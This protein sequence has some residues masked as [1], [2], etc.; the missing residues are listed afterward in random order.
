[1]LLHAASA[2]N[3]ARLCW[4]GSLLIGCSEYA[5]G[6]SM[7]GAV[8]AILGRPPLKR[9]GNVRWFLHLCRTTP[10][11]GSVSPP[12]E[13][14]MEMM[15]EEVQLFALQP[16]NS[17][18]SSFLCDFLKHQ[19]AW[20]A[21]GNTDN[22]TYGAFIPFMTPLPLSPRQKAILSGNQTDNLQP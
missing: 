1:M 7:H 22:R 17:S 2:F 12:T 5:R 6:L 3:L 21:V 9:C 18:Q 20:E 15:V 14:M 11:S 8:A 19:F 13:M 4:S 16:Q 10:E